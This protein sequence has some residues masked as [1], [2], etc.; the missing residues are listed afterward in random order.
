MA[1][2]TPQQIEKISEITR[3]FRRAFAQTKGNDKIKLSMSRDEMWEITLALE[4]M[5]SIAQN[6]IVV[7]D[8]ALTDEERQAKEL[9]TWVKYIT[10]NQPKDPKNL[11]HMTPEQKRIAQLWLDETRKPPPWEIQPS[12]P[13]PRC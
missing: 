5:V 13:W 1:I 4:A 8:E 3:G 11:D 2:L 7:E 6:A 12:K 9:L 10:R